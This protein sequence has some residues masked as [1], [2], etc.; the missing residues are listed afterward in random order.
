MI[1]ASTEEFLGIRNHCV[2]EEEIWAK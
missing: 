1:S 2:W